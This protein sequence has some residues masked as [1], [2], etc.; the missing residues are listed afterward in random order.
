MSS[1]LSKQNCDLDI[2][3]DPW[4]ENHD[5]LKVCFWKMIMETIMLVTIILEKKLG[6]NDDDGRLGDVYRGRAEP[7][8]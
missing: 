4:L 3:D 2:L 1:T 6:D 7:Q 5:M 8:P